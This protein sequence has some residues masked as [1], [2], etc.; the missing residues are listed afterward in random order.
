MNGDGKPDILIAE[1]CEILPCLL[2][3]GMAGVLLGNGDGTFQPARTFPTNGEGADSIVAADINGDGKLDLLVANIAAKTS[4]NG[5]VS[6]LLGKGDGTFEAATVYSTVGAEAKSVAVA[7]VNGDGKLDLVVANLCNES[8]CMHIFGPGSVAVLL[9]NGDGTFQTAET[10]DSGGSNAWSVAVTDVNGDSKP[11]ILVAHQCFSLACGTTVGVLLGNGDGTFQS[12]KSY[13][14]GGLTASGITAADVNGDGRP[15]ILVANQATQQGV[16]STVAVLLGT[17]DGSFQPPQL[18]FTGGLEATSIV[19]ADVNGDGKPDAIVSNL[20]ACGNAGCPGSVGVLLNAASF[21]ASPPIITISTN[22]RTLWPPN[23]KMVP[24]HV[25][26][27]VKDEGCT[28]TKVTYAVTD[29]YGDLQLSG[30]LALSSTGSF[31]FVVQLQ[32]SRHGN[33][34]DGRLY[35]VAVTATN[36][37]DKTTSQT[38]NI[39]VPHDQ[40]R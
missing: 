17:G 11:D 12:A 29:E 35:T 10:Y 36:S 5:V 37:D 31:A 19:S 7:D 28:K 33:D 6:V 16:P 15:D 38:S 1:S 8:G 40:R 39:S 25:F 21:C 34:L 9:G 14:S 27:A 2:D 32:A 4:N 30:P 23:G 13:N 22:P 24:V 3:D 26:G 20:F 18:F